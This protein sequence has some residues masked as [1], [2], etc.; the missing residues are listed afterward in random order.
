MTDD[1]V[2]DT[3]A[4]MNKEYG[5]S[6]GTVGIY[7]PDCPRLRIGI[8][9]F[10]IA[11]GGGIALGRMNMFWGTES[12]G[13]TNLALKC[14]AAF[15]TKFPELKC[16][17]I[18]VEC[19]LT[20]KWAKAMGV[21]I[22]KLIYVRPGYAEQVVNIVERLL[23]AED[24]GLIVIDS[25][26]AMTKMQELESDAEKANV[27]GVGLAIGKLVRKCTS[28]LNSASKEGR[29][30]TLIWINQIRYKV[31]IVF[32]N[33]ETLPGGEAQKYMATLR[34]RLSGKNEMDAQV[35]K[36][37][38]VMKRTKGVL[39]KWKVPIIAPNL[40]Y[41]MAMV[42]HKGLQIGESDDWPVIYQFLKEYDLVGKG[43]NGKGWVCMG[44][45]FK[46][47]SEIKE[48]MKDSERL[49]ALMSRIM[50]ESEKTLGDS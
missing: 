2:E 29:I 12:S 23:H 9:A 13:K 42:P 37:M 11:S 41:A 50:A 40:E 20:K 35:S 3:V 43:E 48:Y 39:Q 46:T 30:P 22:D 4:W 24:C 15:Q 7:V 14:V 5:E 10:D 1:R 17:F 44:E 34:V 16:V 45:E 25:I 18:D 38:P 27:G 49:D 33:P 31:G 26:A 21:D 28:A 19:T 32:G 47:L 8:M 6:T 36:T